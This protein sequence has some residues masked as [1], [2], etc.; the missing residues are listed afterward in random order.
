VRHAQHRKEG[1]SQTVTSKKK[2]EKKGVRADGTPGSQAR[3]LGEQCIVKALS[4]LVQPKESRRRSEGLTGKKG[5]MV[6]LDA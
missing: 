5:P 6:A 3:G 2:P 4:I 1:G